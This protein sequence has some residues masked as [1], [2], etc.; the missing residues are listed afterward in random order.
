MAENEE[1]APQITDA[2]S[3]ANVTAL[4][5]TPSFALAQTN[6]SFA[7][8]QGV[9]FA[10]MI[11]EQQQASTSSAAATAKSIQQLFGKSKKK[12]PDKGS[13]KEQHNDETCPF[14]GPL[15]AEFG[16]CPDKTY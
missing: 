7:Q 10:N 12:K 9:L 11:S 5:H 15:G 2:V 4:G 16:A 13:K 8:A 1:V 14:N 6:L 3:Q